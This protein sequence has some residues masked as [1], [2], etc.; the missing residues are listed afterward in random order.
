VVSGVTVTT[1]LP[2][3]RSTSL[4]RIGPPDIRARLIAR[5]TGIPGLDSFNQR[6]S[7]KPVVSSR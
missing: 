6:P 1:W 7:G 3:T 4:M 5:H 2:L